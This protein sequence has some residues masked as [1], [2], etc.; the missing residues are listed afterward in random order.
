MQLA[1]LDFHIA[2]RYTSCTCAAD[3]ALVQ[4]CP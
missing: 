1:E 2:T 3:D 4:A